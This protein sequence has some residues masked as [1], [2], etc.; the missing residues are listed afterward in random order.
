I[1]NGAQEAVEQT[2]AQ[3]CWTPVE[4]FGGQTQSDWQVGALSED[5]RAFSVLQGGREQVRVSWPLGG[6]HNAHNALAA[7]LAARHVGVP[8][9]VGAAALAE[10]RGVKRRLE[11][12]GEAAGVRVIDDFAHHPTAIEAT[13]AALRAQAGSGRVLAVVEPRSN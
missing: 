2:L 7:L 11:L 12:R 3:G 8:L 4:R 13:I 5:G 10:F 1:A 9:A 6:L